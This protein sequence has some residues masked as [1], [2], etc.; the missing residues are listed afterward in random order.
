MTESKLKNI[1]IQ[2][3]EI[4]LSSTIHGLPNVV[5]SENIFVKVVWFGLFL[6]FCVWKSD[7]Y[8][9]T[10]RLGMELKVTVRIPNQFGIRTFPVSKVKLMAHCGFSC[11][12][13]NL[14]VV[15]S[16]DVLRTTVCSR[17]KL[18]MFF[19]IDGTNCRL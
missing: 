15:P 13:C 9:N 12:C 18:I 10:E 11:F 4:I 7:S 17:E 19:S 3:K 5:R 8:P 2:C 1:K 14:H 16:I 6:T